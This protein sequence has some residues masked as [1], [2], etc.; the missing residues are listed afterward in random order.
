MASSQSPREMLFVSIRNDDIEN[1]RT[2]F[3]TLQHSRRGFSAE[4]ALALAIKKASVPI[5]KYL[6][7]QEK[8]PVAGLQP[9]RVWMAVSRASEDEDRGKKEQ[10]AIRV[11]QTLFEHGWDVNCRE[12]SE[13][14]NS[15]GDRLLTMV[16]DS[17]NLVNWLL[18]HG[19]V[20]ADPPDLDSFSTPPILERVASTGSISTF[21]LLRDNGAQITQRLLHR[22]VQSAAY[23]GDRETFE[24]RMK[25]VRFLVED[26]GCDVNAMDVVEGQ[27]LPNHW[28]TPAAYAMQTGYQPA[29][30]KV[31][32]I[33]YLLEKGA[34]S[35]IKDCFGNLSLLDRAERAGNQEILDLIRNEKKV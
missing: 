10:N 18:S 33:K 29:D 27:Q 1:F 6:L 28:G 12:S 11:W 32:L 5:V 2:A 20:A 24:E 31:E 35:T 14:Q 4:E 30:Q 26:L 13:S 25:M 17:E 16:C 15:N 23:S 34:D 22:A 21:R 9:Y 7:E 3:D 19:A 8:T